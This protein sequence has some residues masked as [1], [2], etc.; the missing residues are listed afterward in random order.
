MKIKKVKENTNMSL[1]NKEGQ[2]KCTGI[3]LINEKKKIRIQR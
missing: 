2:N 1:N 3:F